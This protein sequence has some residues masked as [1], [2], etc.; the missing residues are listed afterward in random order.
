MNQRLNATTWGEHPETDFKTDF[1][2]FVNRN[3]QRKR[4]HGSSALPN[5]TRY[6]VVGIICMA[7]GVILGVMM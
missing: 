3:H 5:W 6:A 7:I 1:I 2:D 4:Q